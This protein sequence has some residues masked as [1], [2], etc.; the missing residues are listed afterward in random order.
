MQVKGHAD[1][2][3]ESGEEDRDGG[4]DGGTRGSRVRDRVPQA[5]EVKLEG[6]LGRSSPDM[7]DVLNELRRGREIKS[8]GRLD[9]A[10]TEKRSHLLNGHGFEVRDERLDELEEVSDEEW[11][12]PGL[13]VLDELDVGSNG[14][15]LELAAGDDEPEVTGHD[16][17]KIVGSERGDLDS[18]Q[19]LDRVV[20]V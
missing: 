18:V 10:R 13:C 3:F 11:V 16:E 1:L 2:G 15:R 19:V 12:A 4:R 14:R 9:Y 7:D 5:D 8:A 6:Q 20:L 17:L